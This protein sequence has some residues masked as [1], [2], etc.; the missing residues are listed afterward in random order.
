M[1]GWRP[2]ARHGD[3]IYLQLHGPTHD[4]AAVGVIAFNAAAAGPLKALHLRDGA[5]VVHGNAG[6]IGGAEQGRRAGG[7]QVDDMHLR[8]GLGQRQSVGVGGVIVQAKDRALARCDGIA[9]DVSAYRAAE[10]DGGLVVAGKHQRALDGT[11]GHNDG[12]RPHGAHA[13]ARDAKGG[14]GHAGGAALDHTDG[15]AVVNAKRGAARVQAHAAAGLQL[16]KHM[17]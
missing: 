8:S 10:H 6:A 7:P 5:A 1:H 2:A 13:L 14:V 11:A 9:V 12:A 3:Q 16:L 4:A 17:G 15:I